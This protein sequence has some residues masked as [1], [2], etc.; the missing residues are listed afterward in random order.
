MQ[1]EIDMLLDVI[2]SQF[3][4]STLPSTG[5]TLPKPERFSWGQTQTN[6]LV[7]ESGLRLTVSTVWNDRERVTISVSSPDYYV[8]D[9]NKVRT[10]TAKLSRGINAIV[11]DFRRKQFGDIVRLLDELIPRHRKNIEDKRR[12]NMFS[13]NM[14]ARFPKTL[15]ASNWSNQTLYMRSGKSFGDARALSDGV[16]VEMYISHSQFEALMTI[17]ESDAK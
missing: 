13:E 12:R 10:I 9:E 1:T 15:S 8:S 14:L 3:E 16:R 5:E 17:I 2:A 7:F 6:S 11:A 4:G